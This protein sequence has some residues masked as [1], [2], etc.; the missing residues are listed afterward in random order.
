MHWIA[1]V[2]HPT[3]E[4]LELG[5]L[6]ASTL[7][8]MAQRITS[9]LGTHKVQTTIHK[10][11]LIQMNTRNCQNAKKVIRLKSFIKLQKFYTN[12]EGNP[13]EFLLRHVSYRSEEKTLNI[14]CVVNGYKKH[15]SI[16][17]ETGESREDTPGETGSENEE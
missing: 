15:Y 9:L 11:D 6:E 14:D 7:E 13:C 3:K 12:K 16:K 8:E 4:D 17:V 5:R 2:S 10:D 1:T